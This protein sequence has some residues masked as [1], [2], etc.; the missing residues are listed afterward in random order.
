MSY[1]IHVI[2]VQNT[3]QNYIWLI[4]HTQSQCVVVIDPTH[5]SIVQ[6][7]CKKHHLKIAQIWLTHWHLDHTQGVA[8]LIQNQDIPVYGPQKELS[9]IPTLTKY[10]THDSKFMFE[11][12]RIHVIETIGHTLGHIVYWIPQLDAI[13][14]GDTLFAM[15][16]GRVSEGTHQQMFDSLQQFKTLPIVTKIYCTHE[17]TLTNAN[18]ALTIEPQN[19][20]LQK[21]QKH[22]QEL[23]KNHQI[24]LPSTLALE[25]E[26][27]LFLKATTVEQFSA[28]RQLKDQY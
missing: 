23:R 9:K 16:C 8:G 21:R 7:Y 24:T 15:G 1:K 20:K 2:N 6:A 13:F 25:L 27:N 4:E 18:F 28:I 14:V 5:S 17:Y 19:L 26:T 10:L 11:T 22:I 3:L 12:L